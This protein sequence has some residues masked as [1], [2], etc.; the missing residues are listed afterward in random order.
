MENYYNILKIKKD[1]T[2]DQIK[3]AYLTLVTK[4]HPDV[5]IGDKE[6]ALQITSAITE[7]YSVLKDEERRREYDIAHRVNTI[8]TIYQDYMNKVGTEN[9]FDVNRP[10]YG[11]NYDQE[12]SRKYFKN[13]KIKPRHRGIFKKLFTSKLFYCLL[14]VF[15]IEAVI[16]YFIYVKSL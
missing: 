2:T 7:A 9:N 10:Y 12:T 16:I 6:Y 4:F 13:A 11:K 8:D 14:F 1:A 5:Y 15:A 3:R